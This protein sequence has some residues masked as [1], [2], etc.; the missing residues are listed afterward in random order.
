MTPPL[1]RNASYLAD[2][3]RR[4]LF[5]GTLLLLAILLFATHSLWLPLASDFLVVADP[6]QPADAVVPLAGGLQRAN[7]AAV[8]FHQGYASSYV[9]TDAVHSENCLQARRFDITGAAL[10]AGIPQEHLRM[11]TRAVSSTYEEALAVKELAQAQNWQSLIVVT[12][13][14][15]TRRARL[16]FRH[17]FA[18]MSV[19]ITVRPVAYGG[20]KTHL[21][22]QDPDERKMVLLEYVKLLA[23]R[24]GYRA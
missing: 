21:W 24:V 23:F 8:L 13:P 4:F 10:A 19:K 20:D 16:I 3:Q 6:L 15:H 12:S 5:P 17:I 14:T 7:Y 2:K 22:W 18:D 1:E 11:T 9:V